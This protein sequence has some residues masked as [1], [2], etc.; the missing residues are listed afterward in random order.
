MTGGA[1]MALIIFIVAIVVA[2]AMGIFVMCKKKPQDAMIAHN[3]V[4]N[5]L[6]GEDQL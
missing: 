6:E 3:A 4:Y 5:T 1:V 2:C